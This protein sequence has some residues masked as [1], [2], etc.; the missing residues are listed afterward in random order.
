[1]SD[2]CDGCG[3]RNSE[4]KGGGGV[5]RRG[6]RIEL[7]VEAPEDLRRDVIKAETATLEIPELELEVTTGTLG[8]LI[9]TVEGLVESVADAQKLRFRLAVPSNKGKFIDEGLWSLARYPNYFG[10]IILQLGLW[11]LCVPSFGKTA[12]WLTVLGPAF[13]AFLLLFVSGVPL[14]EAQAKARWG[15]GDS[16]YQAYRKRTRLLVPVPKLCGGRV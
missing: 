16:G 13:V 5:P 9:T 10:E 3:Y 7:R 2:A 1:M 6:R 11:L 12:A 15:E 8:G 14:Q 4:V